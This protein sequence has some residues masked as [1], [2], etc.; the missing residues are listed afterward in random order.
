MTFAYQSILFYQHMLEEQG[1]EEEEIEKNKKGKT[2]KKEV[3]VFHAK[4]DIIL[5]AKSGKVLKVL[6]KVKH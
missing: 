5:S 1:K 4:M 3:Q 2:R 6:I